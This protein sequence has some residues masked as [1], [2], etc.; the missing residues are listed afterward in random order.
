MQVRY[1]LTK[2]EEWARDIG[3]EKPLTAVLVESIQ[4]SQLLQVNKSSLDDVEQ[5]F[6][7]CGSLN[8]LQMQKILTMYVPARSSF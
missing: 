6:Q 3:M 5:I 4:I 1:N 7:T 2:L 8:S